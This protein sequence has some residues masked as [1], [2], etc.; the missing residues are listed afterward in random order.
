MTIGCE[1]WVGFEAAGVF[2]VVPESESKGPSLPLVVVLVTFRVAVFFAGAGGSLGF[3]A[4]VLVVRVVVAGVGSVGV[5]A[6]ERVALAVIAAVE[7]FG[8]RGAMLCT[9]LCCWADVCRSVTDATRS[10]SRGSF[11]YSA[12]APLWQLSV[13]SSRT[14]LLVF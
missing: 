9:R 11:T 14:P 6:F 12:K 2:F 7:G 5:V 3:I 13:E 10:R 1:L 8:M 4:A